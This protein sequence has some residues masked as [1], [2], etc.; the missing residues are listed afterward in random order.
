MLPFLPF[1]LLGPPPPAPT[2]AAA[3]SA[4][5]V[6]AS[7]V[8]D[9]LLTAAGNL[10]VYG[11]DLWLVGGTDAIAQE[12]GTALRLFLD[13]AI[14]DA[15]AGL[16]WPELLGRGVGEAQIAAAVRAQLQTVPGVASVD[17][18]TI[19]T[20]Q[21]TRAASI[22]AD[23]TTTDGAQLTVTQQVGV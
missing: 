6:S 21:L 20:D 22:G 5:V 12:C 9:L 10:W 15:N 3:A 4:P 11:G 2:I 19:D 14:M 7:P 18:I 1:P 16:P 23:V 13:E 17:N 8:R